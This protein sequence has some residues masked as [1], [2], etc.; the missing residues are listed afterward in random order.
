LAAKCQSSIRLLKEQHPNDGL[1][2]PSEKIDE[3]IQRADVEQ[4]DN[5]EKTVGLKP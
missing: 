5:D 3:R 2:D 1:N 4:G